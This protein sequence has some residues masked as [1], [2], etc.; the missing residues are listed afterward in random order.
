M[1]EKY[2]KSIPGTKEYM[3]YTFFA[4]YLTQD[5][6]SISEAIDDFKNSSSKESKILLAN[7]IYNFL[8]D[9]YPEDEKFEFIEELSSG[10]IDKKS[11]KEKLQFIRNAFMNY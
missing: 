7:E 5:V 10:W 1:Y 11:A 8:Q 9:D 4:A 3:F 6:G 2:T